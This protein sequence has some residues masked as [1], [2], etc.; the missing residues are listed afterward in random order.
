MSE[1]TA[2]EDIPTSA[3]Q[4]QEQTQETGD[5]V[6]ED[7]FDEDEKVEEEEEALQR[8]RIVRCS[9]DTT[10]EDIQG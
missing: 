8:V 7:P 10:P 6:Q 2:M 3:Q 4:G 9:L 1:D 5:H